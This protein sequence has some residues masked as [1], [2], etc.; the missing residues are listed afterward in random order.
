MA[1][2]L[3]KMAHNQE[4]VGSSPGTLYWMDVRGILKQPQGQKNASGYGLA[5]P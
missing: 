3:R 2:W 1:Y 4:V 5:D